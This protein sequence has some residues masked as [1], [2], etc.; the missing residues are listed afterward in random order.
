MVITGLVCTRTVLLSPSTLKTG[1]FDAKPEKATLPAAVGLKVQVNTV[2]PPLAV[3]VVE[4][5][6]GLVS[7]TAFAV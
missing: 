1:P 4:D 6:T 2:N 7:L 5:G 3:M